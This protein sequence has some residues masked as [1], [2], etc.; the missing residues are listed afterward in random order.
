VRKADTASGIAVSAVALFFGIMALRMPWY[1]SEWGISAAPGL[2]PLT[3]S[4]CLLLCGL[5]LIIRA[6][7]GVTHYEKMEAMA[8]ATS[9]HDCDDS[10]ETPQAS[11][12]GR[13]LTETQRV[14][15]TVGLSLA[16]VLLL[17][18][19]PYAVATALYIFVFI[20]VFQGKNYLKAAIISVISSAVV[21]FAF[22]RI[23]F[24]FLP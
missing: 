22:A 15:L 11:S 10:A 16:Y 24:V 1:D 4:S 6:R 21:W 20:S 2:V 5:F 13:A 23:F 3:L 9:T 18:R 8:S 7:V 14:L 17:G 12:E 19:I